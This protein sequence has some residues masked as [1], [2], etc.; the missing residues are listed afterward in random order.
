VLPRQGKHVEDCWKKARRT[1]AALEFQA[2]G[3]GGHGC[4]DV[5]LPERDPR[6]VYKAGE[7]VG[8]FNE[9]SVNELLQESTLLGGIAACLCQPCFL[10]P[11]RCAPA[12]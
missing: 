11:Q 4:L 12:A 7:P 9:N 3:A 10:K 1:Q 5:A 8:A 6:E 2:L